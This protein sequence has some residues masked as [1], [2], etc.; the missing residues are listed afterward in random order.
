ML[1]VRHADVV[2]VL[3]NVA[4]A[5]R[6]PDRED[7]QVRNPIVVVHVRRRV[8]RPAAVTVHPQHT[9]LVPTGI[10]HRDVGVQGKR[11]A[12]IAIEEH[13]RGGDI[14]RTAATRPRAAQVGSV[15]RYRVRGRRSIRNR[16]LNRYRRNVVLD[17]DRHGTRDGIA[18]L[19]RGHDRGARDRQ[20]VGALNGLVE[21]V[22]T[23]RRRH[24]HL[25]VGARRDARRR[26]QRQGQR[27]LAIDSPLD[28]R[29]ALARPDHVRARHSVRVHRHAGDITEHERGQRVRTRR[30]GHRRRV[31]RIRDQRLVHVQRRHRR[32]RHEFGGAR[33][34]AR[35][36]DRDKIAVAEALDRAA[37]FERECP[38]GTVGI[39]GD[40]RHPVG[41]GDPH[42]V[43]YIISEREVG[44]VGEQR[45]E[46][47]DVGL[48]VGADVRPA[49]A[50]QRGIV[51]H[52]DAELVEVDLYQV[53]VFEQDRP[54][55]ALYLGYC[56]NDHRLDEETGV[57]RRQT[58]R[59]V[60]LDDVQRVDIGVLRIGPDKSAGCNRV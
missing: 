1:A 14:V 15:L 6:H 29:V 42:I 39:Q 31:V 41:R 59:A 17:H 16:R 49:Q 46:I 54:R 35:H 13:N 27:R 50:E 9:Q 58:T 25:A 38:T 20:V 4:V 32:H 28:H 11:R 33:S 8:E 24:R 19:V 60:E 44:L 55:R 5:V 12:V 36:Q 7:K 3:G 22:L 51:D 52:G 18:V 37:R 47:D 45:P 10:A 48:G 34:T 26:T 30:E 56:R 57:T 43:V 2:G 53:A 40:D 21:E 23:Q